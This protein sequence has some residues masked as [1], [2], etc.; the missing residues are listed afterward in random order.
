MYARVATSEGTPEAVE[1][2]IR[3]MGE[4]EAAR[5][6]TSGYGGSYVL[7]DR[8]SG[9]NLVVILWETEAALQAHTTTAEQGREVARV[10]GMAATPWEVYEVSYRS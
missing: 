9:K 6:A 7:T 4:R 10:G 5:K 1:G 8:K 2:L 3:L